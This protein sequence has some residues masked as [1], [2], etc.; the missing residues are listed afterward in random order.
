MGEVLFDF[1]THS[2]HS[3]GVLSPIELIR[4]AIVNGYSAIAITDHVALGSLER[5]IKEISDDCAL[6]RAY[7]DILAIPGVELTHLPPQS[8]SETAQKAKELGAW[9]VVVHGETPVEPVEKGTNLAAL[10]SPFVDILAHPGLITPDEALLAAQN[11]IFLELTARRGHSSTNGH[12][13]LTSQKAKAKL[14]VN[15]DAHSET[16]LLTQSQAWNIARHAGLSE[17]ECQKILESH[18]LLLIEKVR[19]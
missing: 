13:A 9:L 15:S 14:L 8:I 6:A 4:R 12:V 5:V 19:K 7:W 16:D 2:F 18:P 1:H 3:D 17:Q 10:Q 11:G